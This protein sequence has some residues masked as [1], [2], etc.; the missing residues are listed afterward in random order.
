MKF[1][2]TIHGMVGNPSPD[3]GGKKSFALFSF[4]KAKIWFGKNQKADMYSLGI[5]HG[6]CNFSN[7]AEYTFDKGYNKD[8]KKVWFISSLNGNTDCKSVINLDTWN[9]I[10]CN[11]IHGRYFLYREREWFIKTIIAAAV[12][13]IFGLIGTGIGYR[14]G[15][16]NGLKEGKHQIQDTAQKP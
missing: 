3:V 5:I 12:G 16:E 4:S 14:Q 2:A 13:F 8:E 15:Y 7:G 11:I 10:K 6:V 9:K 1:K